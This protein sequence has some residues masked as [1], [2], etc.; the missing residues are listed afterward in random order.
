MVC[1]IGCKRLNGHIFHVWFAAMLTSI[2]GYAF[3]LLFDQHVRKMGYAFDSS[4]EKLLMW[5][6]A[7]LIIVS[8]NLAIVY[9]IK[10]TFQKHFDEINK[11]GKAYPRIERFFIYNCL[12]RLDQETSGPAA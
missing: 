12:T 7:T 5:G 8:L 6:V 11:M 1:K 10:R 3:E 4:F 2:E 9:M